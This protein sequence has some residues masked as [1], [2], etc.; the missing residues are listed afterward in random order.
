MNDL[1]NPNEAPSH[2]GDFQEFVSQETL[3]NALG[4][5]NSSE[6]LNELDSETL[7]EEQL[8]DR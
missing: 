4:I 8:N 3:D 7:T 1:E 5:L 6:L 2:N